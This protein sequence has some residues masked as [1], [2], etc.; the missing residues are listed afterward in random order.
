M[1]NS[2]FKRLNILGQIFNSSSYA[3]EGLTK[4]ELSFIKGK[5][6]KII[7]IH[8]NFQNA[9]GA[10][11]GRT[12]AINAIF[13][14]KRLGVP[15]GKVLFANIEKFFEVYSEWIKA[16]VERIYTTYDRSGFYHDPVNGPFNQAFCQAVQEN[17][18]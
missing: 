5:G 11:Q 8:N 2:I 15:N 18:C 12:A 6:T 17:G 10:E 14:A 4:E 13:H 3:S 9:T 7:L 1:S 16:W